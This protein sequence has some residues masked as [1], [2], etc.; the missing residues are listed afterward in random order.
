[1][2]YHLEKGKRVTNIVLGKW[3]SN[4]HH[5]WLAKHPQ[6]KPKSLSNRKYAYIFLKSRLQTCIFICLSDFL[7]IYLQL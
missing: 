6:K 3:D 7:F 1:M 2:Q 5:M 4:E